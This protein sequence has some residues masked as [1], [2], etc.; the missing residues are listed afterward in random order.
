M[1]NMTETINQS[2]GI[3]HQTQWVDVFNRVELSTR[4]KT[5]LLIELSQKHKTI[6]QG[7]LFMQ[8]HV[9]PDGS[10]L[11]F[12]DYDR[13]IELL[14]RAKNEY[15]LAAVEAAFQAQIEVILRMAGLTTEEKSSCLYTL[16]NLIF[17]LSDWELPNER[18]NHYTPKILQDQAQVI[19]KGTNKG[20]DFNELSEYCFTEQYQDQNN[21]LLAKFKF[22]DLNRIKELE[23][24]VAS[25]HTTLN[26]NDKMQ[27][28]TQSNVDFMTWDM[29]E[30]EKNAEVNISKVLNQARASFA[31]TDLRTNFADFFRYV[32]NTVAKESKNPEAID[33]QGLHEIT[34][35]A[36]HRTV[37]LGYDLQRKMTYTQQNDGGM[38]R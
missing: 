33:Y 34:I 18:E 20:M 27:Q 11:K 17:G 30:F 37:D 19:L 13:G 6:I 25:S 14:N 2:R 4:R 1:G 24:I 28:A 36:M 10:V 7:G 16:Q 21:P 5:E 29:L 12:D 38:T 35:A 32:K 3:N 22:L 31:A 8:N 26:M 9:L 15:D 23:K